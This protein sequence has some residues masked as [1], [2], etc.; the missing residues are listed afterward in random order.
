MMSTAKALQLSTAGFA[1]DGSAI[2]RTP[3]SALDVDDDN[4]DDQ[5]SDDYA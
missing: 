1:F 3:K 4:D 2:R 5:D